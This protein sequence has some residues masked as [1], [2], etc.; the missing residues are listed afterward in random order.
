MMTSD[1]S[2][3]I[4]YSSL[5]DQVFRHIKKMI[6]GGEL[7]GGERIPEGK[8]ADAFGVSRTPIREALRKLEKHGLVDIVPRRHAQVV[9]LDLED[10]LHI[11]QIRIQMDTLSI[12]LLS[13]KATEKDYKDLTEIAGQGLM[14][15]KK[16]DFMSCF[17]KDSELHCEF[18]RRSGNP[19]L[20][21]MVR[22]LDMKVQLLRTE[23]KN[24]EPD[25][26][27]KGMKGH[28]PIIEAVCAHDTEK[29]VLLITAHLKEYYF[30]DN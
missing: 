7:V 25:K 23:E 5:S 27:L 1:N 15:G 13:P 20:Y 26:I 29:A 11:G 10:K 6:L 4:D 2:A 18:A 28:Q 16:K 19:Y 17:E 12:R 3:L 14:Y 21:E 30:P 22:N 9:K 8:I 24:I